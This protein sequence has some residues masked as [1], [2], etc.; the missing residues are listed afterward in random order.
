MSGDHGGHETHSGGGGGGKGFFGELTSVLSPDNLL[1][2]AAELSDHVGVG[3]KAAEEALMD[4]TGAFI[5]FVGPKK[6]SGGGGGHG[7][8]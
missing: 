1:N 7:H 8:H 4:V 2:E 6:G 5:P 3:P